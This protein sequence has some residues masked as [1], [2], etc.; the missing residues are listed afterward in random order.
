VHLT[1]YF[2]DTLQAQYMYKSEVSTHPVLRMYRSEVSTHSVLALVY[3]SQL[4]NT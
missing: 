3:R 2:L 1:R 4:P